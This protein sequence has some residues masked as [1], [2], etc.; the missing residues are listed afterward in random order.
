MLSKDEIILR[1]HLLN[2]LIDMNRPVSKNEIT[3]AGK[4]SSFNMAATLQK[5]I[6]KGIVV[7]TK[8]GAIIGVYPVSTRPTPH[9]IR[10]NDGRSFYAM[11]A[12]D[13]LGM[14][15]EFNQDLS[16]SSSCKRCDKK[17]VITVNQ[18]TLLTITPA[19]THVLHVDI[20]KYKDWAADC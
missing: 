17:I 6:D 16:I 19:T 10:L 5:L 15:Y 14:V 18:R 4:H 12:I 2:Q 11:C 13:A 3:F 1:S 20:E 8:E 7:A 9:N